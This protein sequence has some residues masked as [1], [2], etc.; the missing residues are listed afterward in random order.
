MSGKV[1]TRQRQRAHERRM[2]QQRR[3]Y[4]AHQAG[5]SGAA[6]PV[7]AVDPEKVEHLRAGWRKRRAELEVRKALGVSAQEVEIAQGVKDMLIREGLSHPGASKEEINE[8][9]T[10]YLARKSH[11]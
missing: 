1:I 2:A 5:S 11:A 4:K 6:G 8:A 9:L 3:D 7:R 10:I